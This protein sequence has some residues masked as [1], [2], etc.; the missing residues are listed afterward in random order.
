MKRYY[1]LPAIV[2]L[3]LL[4]CGS[5]AAQQ[6]IVEPFENASWTTPANVI[7]T[8][9][10]A[11]LARQG[12]S[13]RPQCSDAVFIRRVYLD[14][15]GT[16]PLPREV[17]AFL[18]DTRPD[19][20]AKLI[21]SLFLREEFAD[22]WTMRWCDVLRVKSEFPINLWP[23]AVQAYHRWIHDAV[24]NNRP[25]DRFARELLTSSG[26]NFRVP[27]VNFYR[28]VQGRDP[29]SLAKAVALTFM[30]ERAERWPKSRL[31][32]MSAFFSKVAY[33][34]TLEWKEEIVYANPDADKPVKAV[35]PDGKAVT[36]P[37]NVD[38]RQVFA[39]WL[40][41]PSNNAFARNIVNRLWAWTMGRGII[42]E[43]DDIRPDNPP[44]CPE[45]LACL[46]KELV[47]S[48]YDLRH[49][50]RLI[51][52]SR[53]YQQSSVPHPLLD[54]N[55]TSPSARSVEFARYAVRQLDAEVLIDAL[56]WI[57]GEGESYSSPIPEPYTFIPKDQ[58]TIALADGSITSSF[59]TTFGRPSRDTGLLAERGSQ[60]TDTQR[61]YMLNSSDIQRRIDRSPRLQ[62]AAN[63]G[64]RNPVNAIRMIY[65]TLLSRYPTDDE[66]RIA[67][68]YYR[69]SGLQPRQA[70]S[71]LA[72][73]LINSKEFLCR[74]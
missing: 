37:A 68:H 29:T 57:G 30:G 38:P 34:K 48:G 74:H 8:H 15:I 60:P 39:G 32:G 69:T 67:L 1:R 35:F 54:G 73:A 63:A 62:M 27:A 26:S 59:L 19:K 7:D 11:A 51:L 9:V 31:D 45:L 49:I 16:L 6:A 20:R 58:R 44:A 46:E 13:L 5:F 71:D 28:A 12:A 61:L 52:N 14:M 53:T 55:M 33:K 56:S 36:I 4:A 43:P 23:N 72:W 2:A 3:A 66:E 64:R 18:R 21:D 41:S 17:D 40:I 24:R 50:L 47:K 25:Y 22:Y 70:A 42:H 10:A 65:L